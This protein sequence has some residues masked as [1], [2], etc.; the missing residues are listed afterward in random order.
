M[1]TFISLTIVNENAQHRDNLAKELHKLIQK[2][3]GFHYD[4]H[5]FNIDFISLKSYR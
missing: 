2:Y 3:P 5:T 1:M 4:M